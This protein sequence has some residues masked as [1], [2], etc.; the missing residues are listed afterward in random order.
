MA[1]SP[2]LLWR[3][4]SAHLALVLSTLSVHDPETGEVFTASRV[5]D[6]FQLVLEEMRLN[7]GWAGLPSSLDDRRLREHATNEVLRVLGVDRVS[8]GDL[9]V[10]SETR[11]VVGHGRDLR[12]VNSRFK[13]YMP[14]ARLQ[15]RISI[16]SDWTDLA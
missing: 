8:I 15:E 2:A 10:Q 4:W 11:W 14:D 3:P 7:E 12:V 1:E 5:D 13:Q 16:V 9:T 6:A